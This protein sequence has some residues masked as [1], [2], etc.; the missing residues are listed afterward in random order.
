[1]RWHRLVAVL[2]SWRVTLVGVLASLASGCSPLYLVS[3]ISS[4][5]GVKAHPNYRYGPG[6]RHQLD[7]YT[8]TAPPAEPRPVVVFF[9]GGGWESGERGQYRFAGEALAA[10]GFVAVVPDYRVYPE[11]KF[12]AFVEDGA[13]AVRWVHDHIGEFGGDPRRVF[14]MGHSAGAYIAAMLAFD[15][16]YL[17]AQGLSTTNVRGLI[18]LAG[19]YD[20]LPLKTPALIEIFGGADGI[21]QTQPITFVSPGAPPALLLQG[22]D[23]TRVKPRNSERLA[24]RIR[25]T[26]GS[27]TEILYQGVGHSGILL[28]LSRPFEGTAP[29]RS[30]VAGFV[31]VNAER[32][33]TGSTEQQRRR[34][35]LLA[36]QANTSGAAGQSR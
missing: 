8:P 13:G 34:R 30:D 36:P 4:E 32:G 5:P 12:P 26:G 22:S 19:P 11:V 21:P 10:Q 3:A 16:R 7:I 25:Q 27:V 1:M 9:Y 15:G 29:V 14:L 20:F 31:R 35:I 2:N 6:P 28:A 17:Y 24:A 33:A 23:D 18:G